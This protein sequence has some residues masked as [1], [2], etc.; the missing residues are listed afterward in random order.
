MTYHKQLDEGFSA[1]DDFLIAWADLLLIQD[2]C[3]LVPLTYREKSAL[4]SLCRYLEWPTR[5]IDLPDVPHNFV[6]ELEHK[7]MSTCLDDLIASNLLLYGALTGQTVDLSTPNAYLHPSN[8]VVHTGVGFDKWLNTTEGKTV[9]ISLQEIL[10]AI[11]EL[12]Q[13]NETDYTEKL[14]E[15]AGYVHDVQLV[16]G[17]LAAI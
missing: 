1:E 9:A 14:E 6:E 8:P 13:G 12:Q 4:L 5:W 17:L 10:T 7:L 16:M 11:G 3:D 2:C 15:I